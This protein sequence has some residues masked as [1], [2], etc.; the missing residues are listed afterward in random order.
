MVLVDVGLEA[1]G[2]VLEDDEDIDGKF[3]VPAA[4]G[5]NFSVFFFGDLDDL[6]PVL[7]FDEE[8]LLLLVSLLS[9]CLV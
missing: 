6:L 2:A 4:A 7:V 1:A 9:I 3:F 8:D 5:T